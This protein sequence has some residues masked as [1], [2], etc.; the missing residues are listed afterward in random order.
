LIGSNTAA[1]LERQQ[2]KDVEVYSLE[3]NIDHTVRRFSELWA[4]LRRGS[5]EPSNFK[6]WEL[7]NFSTYEDIF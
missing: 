2:I 6:L 1:L 5:L 4:Y 7:T 3:D